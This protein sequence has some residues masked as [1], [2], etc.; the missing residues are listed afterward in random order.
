M[1][2]SDCAKQQKENL[3]DEVAGKVS[4]QFWG[5]YPRGTGGIVDPCDYCLLRKECF[6]I[7]QI[8]M[9]QEGCKSVMKTLLKNNPHIFKFF[10]EEKVEV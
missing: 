8:V 4:R 2:L 10:R 5:E 9:S 3:L 7:V 1:R 6:K